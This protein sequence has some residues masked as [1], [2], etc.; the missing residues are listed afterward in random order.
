MTARHADHSIDPQFL[1]RWSP[2]AFSDA[3]MQE[4]DMMRLL[5]AARW[6]PSASNLQPV[7]FAWGLRGD[8]AFASILAALVPFNQE[9]AKAAAGL[10]VVA[11]RPHSEKNGAEV[12]NVWHGFDAGAAWMSIA[13]QAQSMGLIAHA[14]GGFD[15]PALAAA[16]RLPAGYALHAVVAVGVQGLAESLPEGLRALEMPNGRRRLAE[17]AAHGTVPV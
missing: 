17:V 15:G 3:A 9:W 11:S 1:S 12:A 14:M 4:A 10:V 7:R 6:A 5:E 8:A 2:R 16:V 13:L